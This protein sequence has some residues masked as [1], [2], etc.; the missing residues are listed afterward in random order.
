MNLIATAIMAAIPSASPSACSVPSAD[1]P[2]SPTLSSMQSVH[3][4]CTYSFDDRQLSSELSSIGRIEIIT[5][6]PSAAGVM[7][8]AGLTIT[9]SIYT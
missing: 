9:L 6:L 2:R 1:P 5:T 7:F 3:L 8:L 4:V